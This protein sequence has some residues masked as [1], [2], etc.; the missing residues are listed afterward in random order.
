[1]LFAN[2]AVAVA[3]AVN[4]EFEARQL[5]AVGALVAAGVG[6]LE[7]DQMKASNKSV[8]GIKNREMMVAPLVGLFK[9]NS[10]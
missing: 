8:R 4:G 3:L 2:K 1:M 7:N 10:I 6:G 9:A 5:V